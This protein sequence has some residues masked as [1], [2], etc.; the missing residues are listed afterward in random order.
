[1]SN[2]ERRSERSSIVTC[3]IA[4]KDIPDLSHVMLW[5]SRPSDSAY[6]LLLEKFDRPI[7][8]DAPKGFGSLET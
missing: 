6:E 8:A 1:M 5:R 4:V 7:L 2:E 3:G